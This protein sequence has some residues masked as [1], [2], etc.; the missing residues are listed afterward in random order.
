MEQLPRK[1][2]A[3]GQA[4]RCLHGLPGRGGRRA[5][6][7]LRAGGELRELIFDLHFPA[8]LVG[9]L[10]PFLQEQAM[11]GEH[12][13]AFI[14]CCSW[15]YSQEQAL[16]RNTITDSSFP[17]LFFLVVEHLLLHPPPPPL[18]TPHHLQP[19]S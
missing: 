18:T 11:L 12:H 17:Q 19:Q 3:A 13:T 14:R 7:V 6:C 5:V 16:P 1:N 10:P 8:I 2:A 4:D 9:L 15:P